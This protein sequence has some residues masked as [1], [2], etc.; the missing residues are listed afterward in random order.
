MNQKVSPIPE[1]YHSITPYLIVDGGL[2]AM[3]FYKSVL[4]AVEVL[5]M[6]GPPG[7]LGHGEM[8]FGN[9]FV[10]LADEFP[11]MGYKGP[12]NGGMVS[13]L[14]YYVENVDEVAARFVAAGAKVR[15]PVETQF[16]GDRNGTFEDPFGHVWTIATHVED[17]PPEE[18]RRRAAAA[19][20]K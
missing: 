20:G 18:L 10:M 2:K 16:Y 17:V 12:K 19:H 5:R 14:M 9:S 8:K 7:K 11:E 3:E 4:G 1:G 13:N 6:E 15:R